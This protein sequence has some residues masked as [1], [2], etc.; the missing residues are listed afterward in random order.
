[1]LVYV[2]QAALYCEPCGE[3]IRSD[4]RKAGARFDESDEG[5]FDSDEYPKGPTDEGESDSPSHCTACGKF[6]E[7]ELTPEGDRYVRESIAE[8]QAAKKFDSVALTE[9]SPFYGI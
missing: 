8:D 7:T 3:A 4:L 6:L 5:S 1:M 9:W 2:Y